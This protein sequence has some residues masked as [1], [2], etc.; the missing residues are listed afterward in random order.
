MMKIRQDNHVI[1]R[2]DA[3]YIKNEIEL[4]WP[5][6]TGPICDEN[7]TRQWHDRS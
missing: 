2:I 5:F 6:K 7:E 1:D 3:I 4:P